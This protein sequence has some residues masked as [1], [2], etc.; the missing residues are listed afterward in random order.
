MLSSELKANYDA[1]V[2]DLES[3]KSTH[4]AAI[5]EHKR[6]L[7]EIA[8]TVAGIKKLTAQ[9]E[10]SHLG[11]S[12]APVNG[13]RFGTMSMRWSILYILGESPVPMASAE[14][15]DALKAGG[16]QSKGQS[17]NSN[18]SAILSN[19]K[20]GKEEVT[21]LES[22]KWAITEIGKSMLD[23]IKATRAQDATASLPLSVQ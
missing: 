18:V 3:R 8:Q 17:F 20:S 10:T 6:A 5:E 7:E 12:L 23:H 4:Q 2:R 16:T 11:V 9:V 14:I 19:M 13:Q 22:G 21:L 15:A 1:V